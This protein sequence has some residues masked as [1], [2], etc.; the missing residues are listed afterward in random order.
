[1]QKKGAILSM[2]FEQ[3]SMLT[4]LLIALAVLFVTGA[5]IV[6]MYAGGL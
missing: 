3:Q 2:I 5:F 4:T 1:M 6:L